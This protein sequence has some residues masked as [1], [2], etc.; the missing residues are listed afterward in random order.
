MDFMM[1]VGKVTPVLAVNTGYIYCACSECTRETIATSWSTKWQN[2]VITSTVSFSLHDREHAGGWVVH[3]QSLCQ[4][5]CSL[6]HYA[7][8]NGLTLR[9]DS[10]LVEEKQAKN[11]KK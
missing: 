2:N 11:D 1:V 7:K 3:F 10:T 5:N 4:T 8:G 6:C 9:R